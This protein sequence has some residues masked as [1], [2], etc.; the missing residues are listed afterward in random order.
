MKG[1][2]LAIVLWISVIIGG[3]L[4]DRWHEKQFLPPASERES[5]DVLIDVLGEI[6]TVLARYLWFRMDLFHEVL[7]EQGVV[8]SKQA[9]VL[10]LLRMV[11][12]LD[13]SMTDS[14]DQIVWDLYRGHNDVDK[15]MEILEEGLK[16]NPKSY[17]LTFR[18]ALILHLE[19][20]FQESMETAKLAFPLTTDE[21]QWADSLR[22]IYWSAKEI[23]DLDT[24]K[25]ALSDLLKLRPN[26]PLWKREKEKLDQAEN[27][28][29]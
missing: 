16:R 13:P 4:I 12:L 5:S 15:A 18:K 8:A 23:D 3:T 22:L 27:E 1:K 21:V 19:D 17:E 26:D 2:Y 7:D 10:P 24:Q 11:T 20:R 14:Y 28:T 29:T 25:R 6:K 9:E